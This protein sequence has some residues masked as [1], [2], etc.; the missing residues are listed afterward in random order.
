MIRTGEYTLQGRDAHIV[1]NGVVNARLDFSEAAKGKLKSQLQ[2]METWKRGIQLTVRELKT[3]I[4]NG[5]E[6]IEA[7]ELSATSSQ[8]IAVRVEK[9]AEMTRAQHIDAENKL[10]LNYKSKLQT[11]K[12]AV[13]EL[14]ADVSTGR[15]KLEE[16]ELSS[17]SLKKTTAR[18][19]QVAK[20]SIDQFT[21]AKSKLKLKETALK[22]AQLQVGD[23][24]KKLK[25]NLQRQ[26]RQSQ[27]VK[28]TK[29]MYSDVKEMR[30]RALESEVEAYHREQQR[31]ETNVEHLRSVVADQ[32]IRIQRLQRAVDD[33]D[34]AIYMG[35]RREEY[36]CEVFRFAAKC[37]VTGCTCAGIARLLDVFFESFFSKR[38]GVIR[39]P[40]RR[41]W[42]EW[43]C[44][45]LLHGRVRVLKL[46]QKVD[47]FHIA[48]DATTKGKSKRSRKTGIC[49]NND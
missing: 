29:T 47:L 5:R 25:T 30:I 2:T 34:P 17:A 36:S 1:P 38:A 44:A 15:E 23:L 35:E 9:A 12:V 32:Q 6:K 37:L 41:Q 45:L 11:M 40:D 39:V 18:V 22:S 24:H 48:G 4:A 20:V 16:V 46:M 26:R 28:Q 42:E 14:K 31:L 21:A 19:V 33:P 10:T 7:A 13:R 3:T 27:S 43:R 49:V 8:K